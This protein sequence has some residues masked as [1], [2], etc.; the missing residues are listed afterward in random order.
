MSHLG[1]VRSASQA[2]QLR[3]APPW[4]PGKPF[5]GVTY[6]RGGSRNL[7]VTRIEC[8]PLPPFTMAGV[9]SCEGIHQDRP[10]RMGS[11][12]LHHSP[13]SSTEA[14]KDSPA[15]DTGTGTAFG[16]HLLCTNEGTANCPSS[17]MLPRRIGVTQ[18]VWAPMR[19]TIRQGHPQ[20][21]LKIHLSRTRLQEQ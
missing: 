20:W 16:G 5:P 13:G 1:T 19:R 4:V 14:P 21:L 3:E 7:T 15:L 6:P 18:G 12:K 17:N 10:R 2:S 8:T 9:G 11:G